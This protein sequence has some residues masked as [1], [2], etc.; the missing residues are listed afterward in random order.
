L[1]TLGLAIV[2]IEAQTVTAPSTAELAEIAERGR[3][4]AEYD[5]AAWHA[6]DAVQTA[7][8]RTV[9]AQRYIAKKENERWMVV[10]GALNAD[11]SEFLIGYEAEQL[12]KPKEFEV[13]KVEPAKEETGFYLF[14]ARA[15]EMG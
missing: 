13:K 11:K 15:L 10:F 7:N 5:Q 9:E 2:G 12:E 3:V 4:L 6:T 8:P 14:G 1:V